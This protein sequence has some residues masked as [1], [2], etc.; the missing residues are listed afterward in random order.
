MSNKRESYGTSGEVS[1]SETEWQNL[2]S[3]V[4]NLE[5]ELLLKFALVTGLRREDVVSVLIENIDFTTGIL[6]YYEKKKKRWRKIPIDD[7]VLKLSKQYLNVV[8]RRQGKLFDFCGK[9]AYNVLNRYCK[10]A[11][12]APHPFHAIRATCTKFCIKK[13]W[14]SLEVARL[15]GDTVETI[16]THYA[17]PSMGD[18]QEAVKKKPII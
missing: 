5:H 1:F 7:S 4:D 2:M 11:K 3:V 8:K 16:E 6:T 12:L 14:S 13:G 18:M 17:V 15:T 10:L 9:T